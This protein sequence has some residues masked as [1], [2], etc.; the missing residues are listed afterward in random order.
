MI[1]LKEKT[2][3]QYVFFFLCRFF[4]S[5]GVISRLH[6]ICRINKSSVYA[7]ALTKFLQTPSESNTKPTLLE[8][9]INFIMLHFFLKS[10]K[11]VYYLKKGWAKKWHWLKTCEWHIFW[12]RLKCQVRVSVIEEHGLTVLNSLKSKNYNII[13]F[14]SG[15][16]DEISS[17]SMVLI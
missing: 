15:P 5:I 4:F 14:D 1:Y 10:V 8:K 16:A 11:L 2:K 9:Y 7:E 13:C 12:C 17:S 3:R 6:I